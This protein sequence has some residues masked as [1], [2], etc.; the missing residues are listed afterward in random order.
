M[1]GWRYLAQRLTGSGAGEFLDFELP[2]SNVEITRELSGPSRLT[3]TITPEIGRLRGADGRLILEEWGSAIFP[4]ADDQIRGGFIL[5]HSEM[6]GPEWR[7]DCIGYAGYPQGM[8]Y[9]ES[10]FFVEADPM[11]IARHIWS[12][13]QAQPG[14]NLAVVLDE[15]KSPVR[16][17]E[18]LEQVEFDTQAGPVSFEAGPYKLAWYQTDD[19]GKNFDDLAA[20]TP[21]EYD[22]EHSWAANGSTQIDH[23]IRLYYPRKGR[24]RGD[25]RFAVGENIHVVPTLERDGDDYANE[26]LAL[27]AGEGRDMLRASVA[28]P[29]GRLRRVAVV[30]DKSARSER[31]ARDVAAIE[32]AGRQGLDDIRELVVSDHPHAPLGT[33]D[34]G[35]DILVVGDLGWTDVE[36]WVRVL[37][38]SMRPERPFEARVGVARVDAVTATS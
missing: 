27:G 38:I 8:P 10:I 5:V 20:E 31:A 35:D 37:S 16:I 33:F 26:V 34:T 11:D 14:G 13:L 23:R 25:L 18:R 21:F 6:R 30:T 12:H 29:D 3:A 36:M 9:T 28:A 24:R 17:G 2:L 7:V 32:L 19:L 15:T 22:E 4:E 1:A